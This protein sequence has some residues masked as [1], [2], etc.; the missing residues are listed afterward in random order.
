MS[1]EISPLH[2]THLH[3]PVNYHQAQEHWAANR[4]TPRDNCG[5]RCLAQ[6]L[7][8]SNS[9]HQ[10]FCHKPVFLAI[11]TQLPKKV[12]GR[13]WM[14]SRTTRNYAFK[15][16]TSGEFANVSTARVQSL[17]LAFGKSFTRS[18]HGPFQVSNWF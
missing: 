18:W 10:P 2:L 16:P 14:Q 6:G 11:R 4:G 12:Q 17:S 3:K 8:V 1:T 15:I 5:V 13:A 9:K 7:P